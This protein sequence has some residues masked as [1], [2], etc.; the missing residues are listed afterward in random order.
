MIR[1][2]IRRLKASELLLLILLMLILVW[3]HSTGMVTMLA[4]WCMLAIFV[5]P[6]DYYKSSLFACILVFTFLYGSFGVLSGFLDISKLIG[7]C[8]PMP[9]F[10]V[11][12]KLMVVRVVKPINLILIL[13]LLLI[14]YQMEVF[15]TFLYNILVNGY[16]IN[17]SRQFF[18]GGDVNRELTATL[19]GLNVSVS[20]IGLS[21]FIII[22]GHYKLRIVLLTLF[23]T[24]VSTT[25]FLINRTGLVIAV[26]CTFVVLCYYYNNNRKALVAVLACLIFVLIFALNKGWIDSNVLMTY[27]ERNVDILTA[28]QRT[29]KWADAF[30]ELLQHPLGWSNVVSGTT[31]YAHNMWLDIARVTGIIPFVALLV[32]TVKALLVQFRLLKI[33]TDSFV[34][35][36]TGL[37]VCFFLSCFVEPVYGGL[38]LF[39]WTMIWGMQEQYCSLNQQ[40]HRNIASQ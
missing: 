9:L 22:K 12:G 28:G 37:N 27:S 32:V 15:T 11:S 19:V 24:A 6:F 21:A 29:I 18:L 4:L 20:M 31:Y 25:M 14:C 34:A 10:Y 5:I 7:L 30:R 39:L 17:S 40:R 1:D 23:L 33:R 8:L 26:I 16:V 13:T 38:H 35:V 2:I 36:T 3:V